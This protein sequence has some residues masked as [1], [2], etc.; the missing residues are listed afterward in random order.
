[1]QCVLRILESSK[2][3]IS[4]NLIINLLNF[5]V[6]FL[7]FTMQNKTRTIVQLFRIGVDSY[8]SIFCPSPRADD[9]RISPNRIVK[10]LYRVLAVREKVVGDNRSIG[11]VLIREL[12]TKGGSKD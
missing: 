5:L 7:K 10:I 6:D 2:F 8:Y 11:V 9:R 3:F 4:P 1:M 12:T